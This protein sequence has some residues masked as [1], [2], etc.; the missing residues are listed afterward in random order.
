MA[1]RRSTRQTT[2]KTRPATGPVARDATRRDEMLARQG[3]QLYQAGDLRGAIRVF[4]DL[5]TRHPDSTPVLYF[6]GAAMT[7]IGRREQGARFI[8]RAIAIGP[9]MADMHH[10]LALAY[11]G[12]DRFDD[13]H[14][15]LD[16]A[17][18]L[19]PDSPAAITGKSDLLIYLDRIDEAV[20]LL[21]PAIDTNPD[22]LV[23][24]LAYGRMAKA[25]GRVERAVELL[26]KQALRDDIAPGP[27]CQVLFRLAGLL[28]NLRRYDD[29]WAAMD[30]ANHLWPDRSRWDAEAHSA[31]I[32]QMIAAWTRDAIARVR[33]GRDTTQVPVF[34]VGMPRSGTSLIEQIMDMH[35]AAFGA[36]EQTELD[37]L[38]FETTRTNLLIDPGQ[39]AS[40]AA[41]RL[42]RRYLK[43]LRALAPK[44]ERIS[45]KAPLN[46]RHLGLIQQMM[47]GARII[48]CV[49]HPLDT[50]LSCY[51]IAMSG[52]QGYSFDMR[53]LASFYRDYRRLMR[54]WEQ[55]LDIPILQ[56]RY[57]DMIDDQ[58]GQ[59]RRLIEFLG[60]DW[61]DAC[62]RFYESDR[63]TR[64]ASNEQVRKP[65]YRTS[66]QRHL[67][68]GSHLDE[69]RAAIGPWLEDES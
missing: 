60:L 61:D 3:E 12:L 7:G 56:M 35:P 41:D 66:R 29:A 26:E 65:I 52:N 47:P 50:C 11:R 58:E 49:R 51:S 44:A 54:H 8:E 67:N 37:A 22:D 31:Q 62:L 21:E 63:V 5:R 57:E 17:M 59:S 13:A 64:T 15:V 19:W 34:I 23:L 27:R 43:M 16:E 68:Y 39:L 6:L 4:E 38:V 36:G 45:D 55:T 53:N 10:N 30:K 69:L 28:D 42:G 24:V 40:G 9:A 33:P 48:H 32:D 46:F 18:A 25:A 1:P 2:R 14:R 20:A